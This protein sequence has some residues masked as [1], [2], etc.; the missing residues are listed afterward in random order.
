MP[1][2]PLTTAWK[3]AAGHGISF[4]TQPIFLYAES[5]SYLSNLG[6]GVDPPGAI[7]SSHI[8]DEGVVLGFSTHAPATFWAACLPIPSR[9]SNWR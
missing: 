5:K 3:K 7:P 9:A 1:Q 4:V 6:T 8:L 2:I